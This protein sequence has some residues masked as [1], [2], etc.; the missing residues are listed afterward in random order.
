MR[1]GMMC[2]T[3]K[4]HISGVTNHIALN[5]RYLES[6]GHE[7]YVFTFG[8]EDYIDKEINIIRSPGVPLSDTGFYLSVRYSSSARKLLQSMDIVHVHHP[9]LSG[10]LAVLYCKVQGIPIAFTNHTR[11]D[12]YAQ[13][14]LPHLPEEISDTFLKAYLHNYCQ[15]VDGVIAPSP[16]LAGVLRKLGV[17]VPIEVVPNGVD[18]APFY[19]QDRPI[20]REDLGWDKQNIVLVYSG[21]LGPEK[22]LPFLLRAFGG[23]VQAYEHLRLLIVGGGVER[24]NLEDRIQHMGLT[25]KVAFTG[26][27]PYEEISRY[28]AM[29]D[30]FVTSSI[31]EVHPL[32]VIEAMATGLPVLGIESPGVG[33]TVISGENGFLATDVEM[34]G[35]TALMVRMALEQDLRDKMSQTARRTAQQYAI[36]YTA[37][38]LLNFYESLVAK[39]ARRDRSTPIPVPEWLQRL[40]LHE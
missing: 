26:S 23:A 22:N 4:P 9:F 24:E 36:E 29:A 11:Y 13:A 40:K 32:S 37:Q 7:V 21:R 8:D 12:L 5:K 20:S 6:L 27:V 33:D 17:D 3:Y 2:D 39:A 25:S 34:A 28:L 14:Y 38:Q 16:G 18:L 10:G 35:F 19:N 31:T 30:F 15:A 1:I